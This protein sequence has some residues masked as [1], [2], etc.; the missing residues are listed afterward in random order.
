[1]APFALAMMITAPLSGS[2]SDRYG[3]RG[4]SSLGLFVSSIGLYGLTGIQAGTPIL[5]ITIWMIVIGAG[6]GFFFSPNTNAIMGAVT[7]ERRGIAAGT[8]TMMNNAGSLISFGIGLAML[9]S[10]MSSQAFQGLLTHTH[11]G[12]H[13]IAIDLFIRGLHQ[14]FWFSFIISLLA[15]GAALLRGSHK[16][17]DE[18]NQQLGHSQ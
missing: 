12:G 15:T 6:S 9:T 11:V 16:Q 8:R 5:N 17:F 3:S 18:T 14:A 10:S 4:L 2:L 7:P 1:M 13:G